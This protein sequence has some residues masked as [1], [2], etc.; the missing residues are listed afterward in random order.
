MLKIGVELSRG[1]ITEKIL[2]SN[3]R[4]ITPRWREPGVFTP[5]IVNDFPDPVCP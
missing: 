3:E 1:G 4:G 2:T 5:C